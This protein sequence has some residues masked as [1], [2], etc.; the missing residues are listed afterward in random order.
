MKFVVSLKIVNYNLSLTIVNDD[1]A[2]TIINICVNKIFIFNNNRF[3][4]QKWPSFKNNRKKTVANRFYIHD[5]YSFSKSSKRVVV[6]KNGH[7]FRKRNNRFWKRLKSK[8]QK[9]TIV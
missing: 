7:F 3:F 2:L 6:F 8:Q 5:R 1:P 4:F 9:K